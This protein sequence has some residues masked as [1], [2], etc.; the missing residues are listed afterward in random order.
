MGITVKKQRNLKVFL[1]FKKKI[2]EMKR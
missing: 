1:N 2:V